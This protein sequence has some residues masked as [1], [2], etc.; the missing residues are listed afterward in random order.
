MVNMKPSRKYWSKTIL[1]FPFRIWFA[2]TSKLREPMR[3]LYS[4]AYLASQ[5]ATN[6]PKSVV[7]LGRVFVDGTGAIEIGEYCFLYP[8]LHLETQD[9]ARISIGDDV[10]V[11]RGVHLVAMAG[12]TIGSGSMIG[13]YASIRDAN[14]TRSPNVPLREA[15]H[16]AQ[17]IRIGNEVWIGRGVTILGGVT[18]GDGATIGAN[19]V[20]TRDVPPN[21]T[22]VGV[23][24]RPIDKS[25]GSI[26]DDRAAS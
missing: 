18:I 1:M 15:G 14:H 10:V 21:I 7:V 26:K 25:R 5:L 6:L 23:P 16:V 2:A 22:V 17:P 4:H 19:A 13:E 9:A 20:V 3:R 12:I 8:D 11:S 24:A